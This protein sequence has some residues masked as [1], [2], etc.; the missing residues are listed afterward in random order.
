VDGI[1]LPFTIRQVN[2]DI[3]LRIAE[4]QHNVPLEEAKFKKPSN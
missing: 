4:V 1:K 2:S 3:I